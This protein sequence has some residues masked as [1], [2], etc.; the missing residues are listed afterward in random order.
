MAEETNSSVTYP[1]ETDPTFDLGL[2]NE[3]RSFT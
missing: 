1:P 2:E 3:D